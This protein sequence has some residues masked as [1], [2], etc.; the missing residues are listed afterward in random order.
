[1][2]VSAYISIIH[3]DLSSVRK[4]SGGHVLDH[5]ILYSDLTFFDQFLGISARC[6]THHP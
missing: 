5:L 3:C 4:Y 1:M 6:N 2:D